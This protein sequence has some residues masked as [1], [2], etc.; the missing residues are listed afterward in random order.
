MT[1]SKLGVLMRF[2]RP[3]HPITRYQLFDSQKIVVVQDGTVYFLFSGGLNSII[4][5]IQSTINI[6]LPKGLDKVYWVRGRIIYTFT[7]L[8]ET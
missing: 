3:V 1:V 4:I 6:S 5:T 8:E 7:G 2:W